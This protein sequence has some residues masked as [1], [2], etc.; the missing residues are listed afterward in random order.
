MLQ[1]VEQESGLGRCSVRFSRRN[2]M[3]G[4]VMC[5]D[6]SCSEGQNDFLVQKRISSLRR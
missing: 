5:S 1:H 6:R 2:I 3:L 4:S